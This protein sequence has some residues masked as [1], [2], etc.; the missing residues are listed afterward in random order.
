MV[1]NFAGYLTYVLTMHKV[2]NS[3]RSPSRGAFEHT[4]SE[5]GPEV[6]ESRK[7]VPRV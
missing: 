3:W 6:V 4:P 5:A 1:S 7:L 2:D